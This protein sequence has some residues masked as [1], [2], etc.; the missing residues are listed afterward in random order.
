[1]GNILKQRRAFACNKV[2]TIAR[3]R[4]KKGE[5]ACLPKL[6]LLLLKQIKS[7]R[8]EAV[9]LGTGKHIA[10]VS[11]T[12]M[13]EMFFFCSG[14]YVD[15]KCSLNGWSELKNDEDPTVFE[16]VKAPGTSFGSPSKSRII[17]HLR[18]PDFIG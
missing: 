4:T 10:F 7:E 12:N 17:R 16:T 11:A 6:I 2:L 18:H 14:I 1:M 5:I 8:A 13:S 15:G 3:A 9:R